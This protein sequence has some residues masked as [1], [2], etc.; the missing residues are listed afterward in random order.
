MQTSMELPANPCRRGSFPAQVQLVRPFG[1]AE[2][3]PTLLAEI[4]EFVASHPATPFLAQFYEIMAECCHKLNEE[5]QRIEYLVKA[6]EAR[7]VDPSSP[8][9][10]RSNAYWNIAYAAE[11]DAGNF[12]LARDYYQRLISEYPK[13][14][15][16]FGARKALERMDAIEAAL[17]EGRP[18][19]GRA[20]CG[21]SLRQGCLSTV[22]DT[23]SFIG[24]R[25]AEAISG[26]LEIAASLARYRC[27]ILL[28]RS[29]DRSCGAVRKRHRMLVTIRLAH[30][31]LEAGV[32]D[33]LA[34]AA[35]EYESCIRTCASF[36]RPS[37]K[38]PT[39]NG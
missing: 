32:R 5:D 10:D 17:R 34:E 18:L 38:A 8:L 4:Q 19:T 27:G 37:R 33:G 26:D 35:A 14:I 9:D 13:D 21:S 39:A 24:T 15:R 7:P 20:R 28:G 23:R 36:R 29:H 25:I 11:F 1:D 3:A 6:V 31:Q 30:W 12:P 16:I 2:N 22:N